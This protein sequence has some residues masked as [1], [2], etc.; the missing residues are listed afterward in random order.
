M[1][2]HCGGKY[3]ALSVHAILQGNN[4]FAVLMHSKTPQVGVAITIEPHAG[5][6]G[7][8]IMQDMGN[9][10]ESQKARFRDVAVQKPNVH[11]RHEYA[12]IIPKCGI[13]LL[14][15]GVPWQ[16]PPH[17]EIPTPSDPES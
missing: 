6:A 4:D 3:V 5:M 7:L 11:L 14:R 12:P 9:N 16:R 2:Q 15:G 13:L 8:N 10:F 1:L 17:T